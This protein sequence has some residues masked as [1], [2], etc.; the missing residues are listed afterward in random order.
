VRHEP[1]MIEEVTAALVANPCGRY[2]DLTVGEG[3][4]ARGILEAAP[5]GRLMGLDRDAEAVAAARA[6]LAGFGERALVERGDF[7]GAAERLAERGWR[8]LDGV[9][10]DLGLRSGALDDPARGFS[11]RLD[12]PLDMRFDPSRGETA[13]ELLARIDGETLAGLLAE[14]TTR[15]DPWRIAAGILSWRERRAL[16]RTSDLVACL[17]ARLGRRATPKLLGSVFAALR[18]AVNLEME[19][20]DR[21]LE[22][23]PA[24]L[25]P[26]GVLCVISYQS[27]ED[28]RVK[29]LG[30]RVGPEPPPGD[31]RMEPLWK[32]PRRPAPEEARRNP[33]ARSARLRAL[34]RILVRPPS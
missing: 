20:L 27:Q 3:G 16:A 25:K 11:Y 29:R 24:A 5:E 31:W 33:R 17:R 15:A 1:V 19:A 28:R 12:G 30:R 9:L 22:T 13:A 26:G 32:G 8:D 18:M 2:A 21:V 34:R 14:G 6:A 10:L 4:H 7:A 23:I